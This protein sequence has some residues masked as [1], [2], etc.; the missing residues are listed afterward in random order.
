MQL[1]SKTDNR[2]YMNVIFG[3]FYSPAF[4][5][6]E[7][8]DKTMGLI[9]D[10]GFNSVMFDTKAWEDFKERFE[11]G[12]LSQYVKMQE[13]MGGSAHRHGLAYNFLLLYFNAII[14][15]EIYVCFVNDFRNSGPVSQKIRLFSLDGRN[16]IPEYSHIHVP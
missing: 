4:D 10:L 12:A 11:T 2:P 1:I 8:V 13:Y 5:N 6:E 9:R 3:N 16:N 15:S 14:L 7:F